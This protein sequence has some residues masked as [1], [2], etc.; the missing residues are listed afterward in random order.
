MIYQRQTWQHDFEE[1]SQLQLQEAFVSVHW[2]A[3]RMKY[4][5][6][7][8]LVGRPFENGNPTGHEFFIQLKGTDNIEQYQIAEGKQLSY[9][10]ELVNL[11]QWHSY[12][13]P[14]ILIVWDFTNRIG[15]W[16]HTQSFIQQKL[17]NKSNWLENN[18]GAS[19]PTKKVHIPTKQII[20]EG[21]LQSLKECIDT[22]WKKIRLG[23]NHF[24]ILYQASESQST[25]NY[26]GDLS[27]TFER[28]IKITEAKAFVSINPNHLKSWLDLAALN[29]ENSDFSEALKSINQAWKI[30][31]E[32]RLIQQLRACILAEYAMNNNNPESM[33]REA[34][35][36]FKSA[37][38]EFDTW[39][40][41]NIGNCYS[42]L[43]KHEVAI[44]Y[45]DKALNQD[46]QSEQAAK[47]WN[48]RGRSMIEIGNAEAALISFN[49]ALEYDSK[50]WNVYSSLAHLEANLNNNESACNYFEKAFRLNP[51]LEADGD[52]HLYCYSDSL[53]QLGRY[54]EA[55]KAVNQLL[56]IQP[57]HERGQIIKVTI[58][59]HLRRE[60]ESFNDEALDF[61]KIR[62]LD[63]PKDMLVRS[64]LNLLYRALGREEERRKLI[65][66]TLSFD[67]VPA[68]AL[69][70]YAMLL[71]QDDL[72]T[73]A[74]GYLEQASAKQ[75]NHAIVHSLARLYRKSERYNDAIEY[76]RLALI[77]QPHPLPILSEISDCY[78]LM[79]D[80]K[81]DI[82]VLTKML[83]M[84]AQEEHF[85]NNLKFA[86]NQ[87]G[88]SFS[89]Y[90][91]IFYNSLRDKS[92][93]EDEIR[94]ELNIYLKDP[95][96][97]E[98]H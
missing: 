35:S 78:Y 45:F 55:L 71:E 10:I 77:G 42:A 27:P 56:S 97:Y 80:Y 16:V 34:I 76:F 95:S 85:Y 7:E 84:G 38:E 96:G 9:S 92:L 4:D 33:L 60:D 69:Y 20:R 18:S 14:V 79:G 28:Q 6:G 93:S 44:T 37:S 13:L 81:S 11:K 26:S 53:Y 43:G 41:Y 58:L 21:D 86:L 23:K 47:I 36:L 88:I 75:K 65:K 52:N 29:Y 74:I 68:M 24:E 73:E 1:K 49:K 70:E 89:K 91:N 31:N 8:D 61:F 25:E 40:E 83:L 67:N 59:A 12:T 19:K 82:V 39:A 64:E 50:L 66:D 22:E 2:R 72:T 87:E 30:N 46:L 5:Y 54:K 3:E 62:L 48:N 15:Y 94:A 32:D 17:S 90:L 98:P 63:N 57:I 51:N